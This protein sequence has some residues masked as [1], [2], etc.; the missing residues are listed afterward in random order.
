MSF[1]VQPPAPMTL[2]VQGSTDVFPVSEIFCVGR[3]YADHT[4]EMG[5]DPDREPPFFFIKPRFS[6]LS[7]GRDMPYPA[8]SDDVHHEIE[9]VVAIAKGGRNIAVN[10]AM[11][12]VFGYG[13]GIDMT[14][15]D[16]QG[17]AKSAGRPWE[18][19]KTFVGAAPCSKLMP[20][21]DTGEINSG[22]IELKINDEVRQQGDVSQM[23][24]KVPEVI[25]GLSELF[26]LQAGDLI[27]TG[28]P[29]GVGPIQVGDRIQGTIVDLPELSFSVGSSWER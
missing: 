21:A 6:L 19:G 8:F 5:G 24:W 3:N 22:S 23:I 18:A 29:A 20:I 2:P 16:L 7:D 14:R 13:I 17:E 28:T 27:F 10:E 1:V 15:R 26:L 4:I 11:S 9:L 12:H 25:S